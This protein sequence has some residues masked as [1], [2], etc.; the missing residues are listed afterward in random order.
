M[1][2]HPVCILLSNV[3]DF[4]EIGN[5]NV[6][7]NDCSEVFGTSTWGAV[8]TQ[9]QSLMM[10]CHRQVDFHAVDWPLGQAFWLFAPVSLPLMS[11]ACIH[12]GLWFSKIPVHT[13]GVRTV[14]KSLFIMGTGRGKSRANH[15]NGRSCR[16]GSVP[17]TNFS[18]DYSASRVDARSVT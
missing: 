3:F 17:R 12:L 13:R 6:C 10:S 7:L 11:S 16:W 8:P 5:E 15:R 2:L 4:R 18:L 14:A 1:Q 9:T